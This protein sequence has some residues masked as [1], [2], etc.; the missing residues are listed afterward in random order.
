[1]IVERHL[2]VFFLV[3]VALLCVSSEET[4]ENDTEI[5]TNKTATPA[6]ATGGGNF[7]SS[8]FDAMRKFLFCE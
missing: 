8:A 6:P 1:M 5:Q 2:S 7:F 4:A 3:I